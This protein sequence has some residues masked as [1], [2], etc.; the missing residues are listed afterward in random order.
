MY[1]GK[2]S[3]IAEFGDYLIGLSDYLI[4]SEANSPPASRR[5]ELIALLIVCF[6]PLVEFDTVR[7]DRQVVRRVGEVDAIFVP[8]DTDPMLQYRV[9][10]P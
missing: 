2:Q 5:E 1:R 7:F 6:T 8:G 3:L 9:F 4:P 10:E